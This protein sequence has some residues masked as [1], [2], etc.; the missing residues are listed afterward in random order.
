VFHSPEPVDCA[1]NW[2]PGKKGVIRCE[3]GA[4]GRL[5]KG[6]AF[7]DMTIANGEEALDGIEIDE[8]GHLFVPRR[9]QDPRRPR[10]ASPHRAD[11]AASRELRLGRRG[12]RAKPPPHRAIDALSAS[13]ERAGI[14]YA[15]IL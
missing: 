12:G 10:K 15:P 14:A 11:A 7:F 2:D 3:V 8:A 1:T 6:I 4:D 13:P 9:H 5:S